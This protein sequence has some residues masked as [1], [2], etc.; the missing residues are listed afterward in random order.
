[1][2]LD[3]GTNVAGCLSTGSGEDD[4]T[5]GYK[6]SVGFGPSQKYGRP[7]TNASVH[8]K[9]TVDPVLMLLALSSVS[10]GILGG[11]IAPFLLLINCNLKWSDDV[12][13]Q[14][15]HVFKPYMF[16]DLCLICKHISFIINTAISFFQ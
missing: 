9:N 15:T 8:L 11:P 14:Y 5:T 12:V 3:A 1:M 13:V 2:W 7:G 4:A 10:T 16:D 6:S